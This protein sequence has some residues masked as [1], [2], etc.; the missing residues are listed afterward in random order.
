MNT[1]AE[2][3]GNT[4]RGS[5]GHMNWLRAMLL[6]NAMFLSTIVP[7]WTEEPGPGEPVNG[8]QALAT[9]QDYIV[10]QGQDVLIELELRNVST[11]SFSLHR[12]V[13]QTLGMPGQV[14]F[15]VRRADGTL[16]EMAQETVDRGGL[17]SLDDYVR[18]KPGSSIKRTLEMYPQYFN[19]AS[20]R[21]EMLEPGCYEIS[22]KIS[23]T[24]QGREIGVK[25][26]WVGMVIS[27]PVTIEVVGEDEGDTF[28]AK[29]TE[30]EERQA[31][32]EQALRELK[33]E[34]PSMRMV[35]AKKL[36]L[37]GAR[38]HAKDISKLLKD[39]NPTV[40][41][42]VIRTL[43]ERMPAKEYAKAIVE[44]FDDEDASVRYQAVRGIGHLRAKEHAS[45]LARLLTSEDAGMRCFAAQ[46]LS[47]VGAKEHSRNLAELLTDLAP[48]PSYIADSQTLPVSS[49]INTVVAEILKRWKVDPKE[50][51][52][53]AKAAKGRMWG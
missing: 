19:H 37:L 27:N 46:A 1:G 22:L 26:A 12:N 23:F 3:L 2:I 18:L 7:G 20:E 50:L 25:D 4:L 52:Q 35:A 16:I 17:V 51:D 21:F 48:C 13:D 41:L 38:E 53:E 30:V 14:L 42:S 24:N 8:L 36:A 39:D 9:V 44:L 45:D 31:K 11:V 5:G 47:D 6:T 10:S 15:Q 40:R 29:S 33:D 28:S 32:I 43:T 49:T 34:L